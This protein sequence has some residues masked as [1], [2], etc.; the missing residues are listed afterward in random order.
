M[1]ELS[2]YIH[3]PFCVRKCDYCDFL[4]A[5]A[6]CEVRE[7]YLHAL[8]REI[9]VRGEQYQDFTVKT[10]FIGGGTPSILTPEQITGLMQKIRQ[11]FSVMPDAEI[12]ME[13]NPGTALGRE[14][15]VSC[16]EA[17]INRLSIGLQSANDE[18]LRLLGRIHTFSQFEATWRQAREAGFTNLNI[19]LMAALPG[20]SV[21]SYETT[22]KT[23]CELKPEHI[24]A[25]SLIIEEGTP[26][27]SRYAS[28]AEEEEYEERDRQM[29]FMTGELLQKYGYTRYEISNYARPDRE[30]KH[31]LVY[32][33]RGEYLGLG[34]GAASLINNTRY[35]NESGLK[36]YILAQGVLPYEEVQTLSVREQMEE[37][38]FLGL[39]LTKGISRETF[40]QTFQCTVESVFGEAL[41]KYQKEGLLTM[42]R[43]RIALTQ[44]GLDLSNYVFAG[45]LE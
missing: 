11:S 24:S 4:S 43:E 12:S 31:N 42:E 8:F 1:R 41:L 21:E 45:F 38:L 40:Y 29:Y 23:V 27:F 9:A 34:I 17:G 35:K 15:F 26:F 32:W 16:R 14:G 18:E 30:C 44:K 37:F 13:V 22:L 28:L 33:T 25:Y 6:S 39:R 19:D 36:A 20:Q 3:I 2:L 5:P 10:I 7:Q